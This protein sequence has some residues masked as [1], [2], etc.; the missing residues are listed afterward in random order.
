M[1]TSSETVGKSFSLLGH[2]DFHSW[3]WQHR[4]RA[5]S[6]AGILRWFAFEQAPFSWMTEP[7]KDF[8]MAVT[9]Y[10]AG[11]IDW[12][13]PSCP[14]ALQAI[15]SQKESVVD[16]EELQ[17]PLGEEAYMPVPG[18]THRYED[19][20]LLYLTHHCPVYCRHC[21]RKRK[22]S[23]PERGSTALD[24]WPEVLSYLQDHPEIHEVLISGGDPLSLS[25]ERIR[26]LLRDLESIP[27]LHLLRLATRNLVTLPFR[28]DDELCSI[29]AECRKPIY[30]QT[31][32]NHVRECTP[33]AE[34]AVRNIIAAGCVVS[35]QTVLLAGIN[36]S[37]SAM[38]ALSRALLQMRI[39]PYAL[40]QADL[41]IGTR[42]LRTPISK[43]LQI[44]DEMRGHVSGL[45]IPRFLVDL[46]GGGGKVAL[47]PERLLRKEG[48]VWY[49]RNHHGQIYGYPDVGD[50]RTSEYVCSL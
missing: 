5:R 14:I 15:P 45:A 23:T 29:L 38:I 22:V 7:G 12:S 43:G 34:I 25:N 18:L 37:S 27:H 36:D 16:S 24:H 50:S 20:A 49:F 40:F 28:I 17:D 48:N 11:L 2:P 32:F 6:L 26:D 44:L 9:P 19:R 10:Y 1:G 41:A 21:T 46:P 30:V 33:E 13:N 39:R 35:N 31:H 8:Q 42:H 4:N 3:H 47:E